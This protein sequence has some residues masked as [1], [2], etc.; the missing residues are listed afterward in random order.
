MQDLLFEHTDSLLVAYGSVAA[1]CGPSGARAHWISLPW[2][3][4]W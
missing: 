1:V 3:L 2:W 4:R